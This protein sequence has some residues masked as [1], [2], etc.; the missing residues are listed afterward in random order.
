MPSCWQP[1]AQ[2]GSPELASLDDGVFIAV[3]ARPPSGVSYD[4]YLVE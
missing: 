1:A 4:V 3:G 2:T